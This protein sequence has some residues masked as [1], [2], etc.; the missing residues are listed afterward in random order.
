MTNPRCCRD[1]DALA[2]PLDPPMLSRTTQ[3]ADW[4][5]REIRSGRLVSGERLPT[6]QKL[7]TQSA[8]AEP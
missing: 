4:F 7:I 5:A 6:E 2:Q 3:V 8:S 1:H